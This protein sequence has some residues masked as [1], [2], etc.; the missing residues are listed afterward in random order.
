MRMALIRLAC[1]GSGSRFVSLSARPLSHRDEDPIPSGVF[2]KPWP[3]TLWQ[4]PSK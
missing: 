1:P 4:A 3:E 2:G